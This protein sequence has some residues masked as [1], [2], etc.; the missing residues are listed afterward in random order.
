[1][2]LILLPY[3]EKWRTLSRPICARRPTEI[4][5][6]C[7]T[8]APETQQAAYH[9]M[10]PAQP[11]QEH[12]SI[13]NPITSRKKA[14]TSTAPPRSQPSDPSATFVKVSSPSTHHFS[15]RFNPRLAAPASR[16]LYTLSMNLTS[17]GLTRNRF[18]SAANR[19]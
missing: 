1:M 8:G 3:T 16:F 6:L 9:A 15:N 5:L 11:R 12:V 13:D 14:H 4:A 19:T 17:L 18:S 10:H 7:S 2:F